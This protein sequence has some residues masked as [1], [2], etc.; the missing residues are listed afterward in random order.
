M[1]LF[2]NILYLISYSILLILSV[3]IAKYIFLE[4]CFEKKLSWIIF[5]FLYVLAG[6]LIL[7]LQGKQ[8]Q[9]YIIMIWLLSFSAMIFLTRK[10]KRIRGLFLI[11][12]VIGIA[13]SV[14]MLPI[15]CVMM[16]TGLSYDSISKNLLVFE[17]IYYSVIIITIY[18]F[19]KKSKILYRR[20]ELGIWERRILYANSMLLFIIYC[21]ILSLPRLFTSYKTYI[22]LGCIFIAIMIIG[23]SILMTMQSANVSYYK[24]VA[25]MNEHY[26]EAQLKHFKAYQETQ[27]E[28]RR[29][30]HDMKNHIICIRD[31]FE[32]H[33][34]EKL[35]VYLKGLSGVTQNIDRELH[36]GNDIADAILNEKYAIAKAQG[37]PFYIEGSLTGINNIATIDL[38]TIFANAIDNALEAVEKPGIIE[39]FI[40][41]DIKRDKKLLFLSF[42]NPCSNQ[43]FLQEGCAGT[44]KSDP[45][46]HGFGLNNIRIAVERY[47]GDI[48]CSVI[49]GQNNQK[50]FS[51]EIMLML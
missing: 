50:Q 51:L 5:A 28:T 29:I 32:R 13:A 45:I 22:L 25:D 31:L 34:D 44:T 40:K 18:L 46:N 9:D 19:I 37:I 7:L 16:F 35:S 11:F 26:L 20:T 6:V 14:E 41:I 2:E 15:M 27:Q 4:K 33:E 8:A 3:Y 21:I 10:K 30:R 12:P 23:T 42:L 1:N 38:C 17:I 43:L 24:A 49:P 36:I 47:K 39:P 48:K